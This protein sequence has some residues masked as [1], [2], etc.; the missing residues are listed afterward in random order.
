MATLA[1][2]TQLLMSISL[3]TV[4][5]SACDTLLDAGLPLPT[6][7]P[8]GS[9]PSTDDTSSD[10]DTS[11]RWV[12]KE[13][14]RNARDL[15]G[16]PLEDGAVSAYG[17]VFRGPPLALS[18]AGCSELAELGINTVIDLRSPA[19][20]SSTPNADC[21]RASA[22]V[23][24]AP[25]STSWD[26]DNYITSS[27]GRAAVLKTFQALGDPDAYPVY[28]HC[29]LGRDRTG[30]MA[31]LILAALGATRSDIVNEYNLSR[32]SV[33]AYPNIL[34]AT[35]DTLDSLGGGE[36]FLREIGVTQQQLETLRTIGI[37]R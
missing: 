19:E 29:T 14:L 35:L 36:S 22:S 23:V 18:A 31:A 27:D 9:E 17:S 32:G 30:A 12:F 21:V 16:V 5:T 28:V 2:G 15:G 7:W 6:G 13:D 11:T 25:L 8:S 24:L 10:A 33:G 1:R 4:M 37:S 34:E 26:Y 20:R 3:V